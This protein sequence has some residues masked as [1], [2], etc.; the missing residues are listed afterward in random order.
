MGFYA[1]QILPR[2]TD[3]IMARKE[4]GPIRARVAAGLDGEVVEVGFGSG[5][6]VP[7]YPPAVRRVRAVDPA[8]GRTLAARRLAAAPAPVAMRSRHAGAHRSGREHRLALEALAHHPPQPSA[9]I[10]LPPRFLG[11]PSQKQVACH[12]AASIRPQRSWPQND[13]TKNRTKE[14]R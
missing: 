1:D 2:A 10:V 6:N 12:G 5:L 3:V 11:P 9:P 7:H 8:L 14:D 13:S 4:F